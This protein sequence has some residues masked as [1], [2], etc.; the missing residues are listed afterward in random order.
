MT[1]FSNALPEKPHGVARALHR[2]VASVLGVLVV[3][4]V[5]SAFRMRKQGGPG[6]AMPLAVLGLTLFLAILGYSTPSP[7]IPAVTLGN[8]LGGMLML[9]LLWWMG[10]RSVEETRHTPAAGVLSLKPWA[11]LGGVLVLLQISLGAWA[12]ANYAGPACTGLGPCQGSWLPAAGLAEGFNLTREL[13]V[14][15]TGR[16]VMDQT[17]PAIHMVHRWGA[18]VT[19]VYLAGLAL[20][21]LRTGR[22]LR[23]TAI[24]ILALLV[25]QLGLGATAILAELP[26]L[27][28]T[29]HNA[30]AAFLLLAVVNLNQRLFRN[31][32]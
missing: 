24:A 11:V 28:V 14:D 30:V 1:S 5:V 21:I 3:F 2:I 10:Q 13:A 19:F 29:A 4:I 12:S 7:W 22:A 23:A 16:I 31:H 26:L 27:V 15:A 8:L 25:L 17:M 18:L 6:L 20:Q 9:A 32:P